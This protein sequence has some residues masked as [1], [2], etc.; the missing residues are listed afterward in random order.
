[1]R[2]K[3]IYDIAGIGIG[4]FNLGLAA[5]SKPITNLSTIFIDQKQK[6]DWHGGMMINGATLQVPFLADLVTLADPSSNY[7]Y[8]NFLRKQNRLLQ[9]GIYEESYIARNEYN[10]YCSWVCSQLDN[11]LF[12][13]CVKDIFYQSQEDHFK[14]VIQEFNSGSVDTLLARNIVIGVG[15]QPFVPDGVAK[16]VGARVIHSSAYMYNKSCISKSDQITI[17]GSGQSAAEI[18]YD[19]LNSVDLSSTEINWF[20]RS[21]RFYA[22]EQ[23]KLNY[24]MTSPE[25]I[26]FFYKLD[27]ATRS[28]LLKRQFSLYKGINAELIN[29]IYNQL[30]QLHI[31]QIE[32]HITIQPHSELISIS[33]TNHLGNYSLCFLHNALQEKFDVTADFVILATGYRY[34]AP[35]FIKSLA[36]MVKLD[37]NGRY[38]VN[39]NYSISNNNR[40]FVQN[41]EMHTHGFNTPDLGLGAYRNAVILNTITQKKLYPVDEHTSFQRFGINRRIINGR[42]ISCRK[43]P[44]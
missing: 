14:L 34:S 6:F 44:V 11:L 8:L 5:L 16:Q 22:M 28:R 19:L 30:Y 2:T 37:A 23:T 4:P 35:D 12:G 15:A 33:P 29:A 25:Y 39:R 20:T 17:V 3:K 38:C 31:D 36:G 18:F 41:A 13:Y 40:V 43:E 10:R 9:F 21:D 24:E 1:M 42:S 26:N 7:S 27:A 32:S